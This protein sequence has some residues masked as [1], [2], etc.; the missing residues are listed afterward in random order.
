VEFASRERAFLFQE[1]LK[2][3]L[4]LGSAGPGGSHP[5]MNEWGGIWAAPSWV[6]VVWLTP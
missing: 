6:R 2:P 5:I 3:T 4:P 1:D